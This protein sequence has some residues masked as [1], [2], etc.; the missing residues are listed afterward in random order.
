M[1]VRVILMLMFSG[2][3]VFAGER[4]LYVFQNGLR[5]KAM[6]E[7]TAAVKELGYAG[8]GSAYLP[9]LDKRIA[10]YDKAGLKVFSIYVG[11]QIND[12]GAKYDAGIPAAIELLTGT[13]AVVELTV[14][15]TRKDVDEQAVAMV[16]EVAAMAENAGLRVALYPPSRLLRCYYGRGHADC[17]QS[18]SRE[19]RRHFQSLS[20]SQER[21]PN[22]T[23]REGHGNR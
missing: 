9:G 2:P 16:R 3:L 13:G 14:R 21:G 22:Q 19:R 4:P 8:V 23:G 5:F 12:K 18:R 7:E 10:A 17:H 20:L 15:S 11:V 1:L 6:A